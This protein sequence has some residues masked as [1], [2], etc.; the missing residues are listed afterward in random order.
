MLKE[1]DKP[2]SLDLPCA[3][4]T[5]TITCN[6]SE[7]ESDA[8]SVSPALKASGHLGVAAAGMSYL[9]PFSIGG[10][11]DHNASESNLSSSG[12]SSMASPGPSRCGSS[13]PLCPSEMEDPGGGNHH[14]HLG[15]RPSPLLRNTPTT[16][17]CGNA[18]NKCDEQRRGR[19]DSETLSDDPL[20]ESNDEGIGTDH[21]EEKIEDGD[22][23]S[24]KELEVFIVKD[25][26]SV[27]TMAEIVP[28]VCAQ[29][30]CDSLD[31][32]VDRLL[33][34]SNSGKNSLQLP[35][36]VVQ[37][38][39][40]VEKHLSPMSSRSESPLSDKTTGIGRFSPQFYGRNKDQLPFTDSDGLYDFPS[41]DKVNIT[42]STH[43]HR[44]STG[45]RREKKSLR[46]CKTPSP[47]KPHNTSFGSQ[48]L[49]IPIK[50]QLYK[51]PAPRKLSPKRRVRPQILT[52]SSS[53]E[54]IVSAKEQKVPA[55]SPTP[56][57]GI[58]WSNTE[59]ASS[60]QTKSPEASGED[61][62]DVSV[63]KRFS[64]DKM[65]GIFTHSRLLFQTTINSGNV[66]TKYSRT[67]QKL[68]L[69]HSG[70]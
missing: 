20:L 52:S 53:S 14:A 64:C 27:K 48:R 68:T 2:T 9:S 63:S 50:D 37:Y 40:S 17:G 7:A 13:N 59:W 70:T 18:D 11:G 47:T 54:S 31:E 21:L 24:A 28:P 1:F 3:P 66:C 58:R 49:D 39:C 62:G 44:K 4:P 38:D 15:R 57:N 5:I 43:P 46:N 25:C 35:S 41:S 42:S 45:R 12:Y 67:L 16:G 60:K 19:S 69:F 51:I 65:I 36:I 55:T 34:P 32:N 56:D 23:K 26:D 22:L 30:I 10:R 6:M 61:T 29:L 8:E 33:P